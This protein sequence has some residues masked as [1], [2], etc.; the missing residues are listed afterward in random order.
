MKK[1]IL[2]LLVILMA[3]QAYAARETVVCKEASDAKSKIKVYLDYDPSVALDNNWQKD[4]EGHSII[5]PYALAETDAQGKTTARVG[6]EIP[7]SQFKKPYSGRFLLNGLY[8]VN[9]LEKA[10]SGYSYVFGNQD[11][12]SFHGFDKNDLWDAMVYISDEA[13]GQSLKSFPGL[14]TIQMD[15]MDQGY[16]HIDLVCSSVVK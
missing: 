5:A 15:L 7:S 1:S 9:A 6:I 16:Y 2:S 11:Y 13:T 3:G 4:K 14:L 12:R 8:K 10:G